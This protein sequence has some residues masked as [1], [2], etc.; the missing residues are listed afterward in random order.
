MEWH[1]RRVHR[2]QRGRNAAHTRAHVAPYRHPGGELESLPIRTAEVADGVESSA[3][4]PKGKE[5]VA[6][7]G[8][9]ICLGVIGYE[10]SANQGFDHREKIRVPLMLL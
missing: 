3:Y 6:V 7:S 9:H 4:V 8:L 1:V 2:R 10:S 5:P